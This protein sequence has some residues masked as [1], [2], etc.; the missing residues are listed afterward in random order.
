MSSSDN[1]PTRK[2]VNKLLNKEFSHGLRELD[3]YTNFIE[4][5]NKVKDE[6]LSFLIEEKKG[7]KV[8]GYGA[9]AKGNTLINYAGIKPTCQLFMIFQNLN[10]I[11]FCPAVIYLFTT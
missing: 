7:N 1:R 2:S 8:V 11:N 3:T 5:V 9:A 6:L 4:R 10:N